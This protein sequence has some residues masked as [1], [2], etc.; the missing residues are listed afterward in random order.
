MLSNIAIGAILI[1]LTTVVHAGGMSLSLRSISSRS[2]TA[3]S[4]LYL[5][6][7]FSVG[8]VVMIMYLIAIIEVLIWA[9]ASLA[10]DV[11]EGF[12]KAIYF[13][14]VTF[15]TLGYGDVVLDGSRRLLSSLEA[16]NGI[17][18]FGWSTA[19]VIA[20]VQRIYFR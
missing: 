13:S 3:G 6:R 20:A 12:E 10:F 2:I 8:R 14:A 7:V 18:M 9:A 17:I 15:T 1:L 5:S 19:I 4:G 16:I 11:I